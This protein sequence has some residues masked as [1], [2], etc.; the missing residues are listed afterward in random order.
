MAASD[1]LGR[2]FHEMT[3]DEFSRQPGT[4]WHGSANGMVGA[5]RR[6]GEVSDPTHP[7][8]H[9][10]GDMLHVK[11]RPFPLARPQPY[12]GIGEA[13]DWK[14]WD[15]PTE[16]GHIMRIGGSFSPEGT[17]QPLG[18]NT[19]LGSPTSEGSPALHGFAWHDKSRKTVNF[20]SDKTKSGTVNM[21]SMTNANEFH[22]RLR[23]VAETPGGSDS[24]PEQG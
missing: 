17:L 5:H 23:E 18:R 14:N 4:W 3:Q 12:K 2:Q 15:I 7:E 16:S 22:K 19:K 6:T 8:F 11:G 24:R 13:G 20:N 9:V 21:V 10:E 1:N